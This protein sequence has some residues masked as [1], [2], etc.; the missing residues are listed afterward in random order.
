MIELSTAEASARASFRRVRVGAEGE[1]GILVS[2][3][4]GDDGD[5]D[6]A[7]VHERRAAV[8]RIVKANV[9][10]SGDAERQRSTIFSNYDYVSKIENDDGTE[11][12]AAAGDGRGE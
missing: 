2:E 3:P 4:R 6:S 11:G 9:R 1:A 12:A 10:K 7:H 5:R 8:P